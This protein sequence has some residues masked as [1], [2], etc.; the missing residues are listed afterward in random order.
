M[1]LMA[2]LNARLGDWD[3]VAKQSPWPSLLVGNGMS[4]NVWSGFDYRRL[5][6][7]ANLSTDAERI[8]TALGTKNF[9]AVL[10]GLWQT[11]TVLDALGR[12]TST[13]DRHYSDVRD[14][15]LDAV[16]HVH[17][18]RSQVP[19]TTTRQIA[20][21]LD[22]YERVYTLNYDLLPYWSLMEHDVRI[23]DFF[24]SGGGTFD[25]DRSDLFA[26]WTGLYYLHGGVHLWQDVTTGISGKWGSTGRGLLAG[27][28]GKLSAAP[29][30]QPLFVSEGTARHKRRTIKRSEYLS[31]AMQTLRDDAEPLGLFG[32]SLGP[33]D[34]H[35][36]S[37]I[38][39]HPMRP[40][41]IAVRA[42]T[43]EQIRR[44]KARWHEVFPQ[45]TLTF[46]SAES[47]PLGDPALAASP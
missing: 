46:F 38:N 16:T 35:V 14:A 15:L 23:A 36:V 30:R 44:S 28:A 9:E 4:M 40:L 12:R 43:T 25:P 17:P 41:A 19:S 1:Q 2:R 7:V 37:A 6:S 33:P 10:E 26:G 22:S 45:Q 39:G 29:Q 32:T 27:L 21:T 20:T 34:A 31:F 3:A 18:L 11:R 8:F 42:G 24:W 13:M 5:Y 47:H